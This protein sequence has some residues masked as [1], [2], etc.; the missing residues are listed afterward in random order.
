M[1]ATT[2]SDS[3]VLPEGVQLRP[4]QA[5][6]ITSTMDYLAKT[7]GMQGR[8]PLVVMPT[9]T[10]KS[11]VIA[12]LCKKV[13]QWQGVEVMVL[14]H[15]SELVRQ[16]TKAIASMCGREQV[17]VYSAGLGL[18]QTGQRIICGTVQS[19][20]KALARD[21]EVFGSRRVVLI[22][23]AHYVG[24]TSG[25]M[26]GQTLDALKSECP[27]MRIIG[28]TA[29]PHRTTTGHLANTDK[30]VFTD[31]CYEVG[32]SGFVELV[33]EGYLAPLV[34]PP[35]PVT[36]DISHVKVDRHTN[37]FNTRQLIEA[38]GNEEMLARACDVMVDSGKDRKAWI[39]FVTGIANSDLVC[40]LLRSRGVAVEQ[41]HSKKTAE[42]NRAAIADFRAGR[43]KCLISANKLTTGFD[44]PAV[45]LIGM[46][47]P[48]HSWSLHKQMLGRGTRPAPGKTDCLVLDFAQNVSRLGPVNSEVPDDNE[49]G[50]EKSR[51][52][53]VVTKDERLPE[54][55]GY[56]CPSC[57]MIYPAGDCTC[58][59]CGADLTVAQEFDYDNLSNVQLINYNVAAPD[60]P[61]GTE[62]K[63]RNMVGELYVSKHSGKSCI[64][65]TVVLAGRNNSQFYSRHYLNFG[66]KKMAQRSAERIWKML[67]GV[68]PCPATPE[69]ALTR[70]GELE[71]PAFIT[72]IKRNVMRGID[73]D[74][75]V[76]VRYP[77]ANEK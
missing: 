69:E 62:Y 28:F 8:N 51:H 2:A 71:T 5:D 52:E 43:L 59:Y 65:L 32:S 63:V 16:N 72:L 73:F 53:E 17:G 29:T 35:V 13:L 47:R 74:K 36:I 67:R 12:A 11:V 9:G 40:R 38:V 49:G 55:L 19:V 26:Y 45:D 76:K 54:A 64:K 60:P 10:G 14:T 6:A 7:K 50:F 34:A 57:G 30:G 58:R 44:V 22:D 66:D 31:V 68:T 56:K 3:A 39:V 27:Q 21:N 24:N 46:L 37:E 20:Y 61:K 77:G 48:T 23:E 41:V 42:H 18:K 75:M 4:Y 33:Q 1:Q 70:I 15:N 25:S